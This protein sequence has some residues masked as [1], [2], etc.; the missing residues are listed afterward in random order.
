MEAAYNFL[1]FYEDLPVGC[2]SVGEKILELKKF[3]WL[4]K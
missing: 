3:Y 1:D 2:K 4:K